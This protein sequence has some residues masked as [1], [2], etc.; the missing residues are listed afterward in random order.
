MNRIQKNMSFRS[1]IVTVL[2]M[3]TVILT[4]YSLFLV[5]DIEKINTVSESIQDTSIPELIWLSHWEE[6]LTIK[7]FMVQNYID[8]DLCCNFSDTYKSTDDNEFAHI[9]GKVPETLEDVKRQVALLDFLIVNNVQGLVEFDDKLAAKEYIEATYL[10]KLEQLKQDIVD[11]KEASFGFLSTRAD[12]FSEII[13]HSLWLLLLL[14]VSSI[15]LSIFFSFRISASITRPIEAMTKKVDQIANGDY[16]LTINERTQVELQYLTHSINQ[17]SLRLKDSFHT[18]MMDKMYREQIL[19]SLPVGIIT[20][21]DQT[22]TYSLNSTA[23]C[24][25]EIE[26]L[27][28]KDEDEENKAFWRILSSKQICN[29]IKVTFTSERGIFT[30]LVSQS[31]L[32]DSQGNVIGRIMHF[33]NITETEELEERMHQS[34]KLALVGEI[35]AGAAHEIR[36][37]LAVIH[38]FI[39]LMNQSLSE[40]EKERFQFPLLMKEIDRINLIIEEMLL[41]AKPGAPILKERY[42][43]DIVQE[44]LPLIQQCIEGGDITLSV[45]LI[46]EPVLVDSKQMKQVFHNLIRNSIEAIGDNGNIIIS[47]KINNGYYKIT[48]QDDGPGIPDYMKQRIFEPFS[49]SKEEGTGLGLTIVQRIIENHN[50]D[51]ELIDSSETGTTFI[52]SLPL[53]DAIPTTEA[54][55]SLNRIEKSVTV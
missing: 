44:F 9:H 17:M 33:V 13:Q 2:L 3:I 14:T 10:P 23:K 34:E 30:L 19:N 7:K 40:Q 39:S 27:L 45:S 46:R 42:M 21:N 41:Q 18:I 51:I 31:F 26:D 22:G 12:R 35:A 37:P 36:N 32:V 50:G 4:S 47:S 55:A 16:G 20:Y 25:L 15:I 49:S 43:E 6:E 11:R 29:N 24:L 48:L 8:N 1:K 38:G 53:K 28:L 5:H 52:I 54:G